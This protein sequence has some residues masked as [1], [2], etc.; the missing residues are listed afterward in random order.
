MRESVR[1]QSDVHHHFVR[2]TRGMKRFERPVRHESDIVDRQVHDQSTFDSDLADLGSSIQLAQ[3]SGNEVR[4]DLM[5]LF[6]YGSGTLNLI[7]VV[8]HGLHALRATSLAS[9]A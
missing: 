8:C 2:L 3:I 4:L 5:L 7:S 9:I 1:R 6:D